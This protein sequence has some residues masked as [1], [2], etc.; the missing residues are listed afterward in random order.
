MIGVSCP[1]F[2]ATPVAEWA[3]PISEHFRLWEIFSEADHIVYRDTPAIKGILDSAGLARQVHSP[4]CDWNIAALSDRLREASLKET[5]ANIEAAEE[6]GAKVVTVHPGLSSMSVPGTEERAMVRARESLRALDRL[7]AGRD[8]R[9]GI[10]NMP[11]VPFFLG[12]TAESLGSLIEGTDLGGSAHVVLELEGTGLLALH[13]EVNV[14]G[15][16]GHELVRGLDQLL[17]EAQLRRGE[18]ACPIPGDLEVPDVKEGAD[19]ARVVLD[20][21][22]R[23]DLAHVL[24]AHSLVLNLAGVVGV[25]EGKVVEQL[26]A[27]LLGKR[28]PRGNEVVVTLLQ[29]VGHGAPPVVRVLWG[30]LC[31]EGRRHANHSVRGADASAEGRRR[32]GG[33]GP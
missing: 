29:Q 33:D 26:G 7:V 11:N 32:R 28:H 6:L 14:V 13:P 17:G 15:A 27:T 22:G 2:S 1:G 30:I 3:G 24:P 12:R 9:L 8:I 21:A 16:H 18:L 23:E 31:R 5:V 20:P 4:I 19:A 25:A 10:E